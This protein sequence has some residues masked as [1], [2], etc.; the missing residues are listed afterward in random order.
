[1][2]RWA[3]LIE[4]AGRRPLWLDDTKYTAGLLGKGSAPWLR[5][6]EWANWRRTALKLLNPDVAV[7]DVSAAAEAWAV[8]HPEALLLSD[9]G[10]QAHL[11]EVL[12]GLRAVTK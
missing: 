10:L 9:P 1:M 5:V 4:A 3:E 7:L 6:A 12:L 11:R 2:G 8:E